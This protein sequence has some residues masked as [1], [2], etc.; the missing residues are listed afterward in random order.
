ML[1]YRFKNMADIYLRCNI[2]LHYFT[3]HSRSYISY[4]YLQTADIKQFVYKRLSF[5]MGQPYYYLVGHQD[6]S[7]AASLMRLPDIVCLFLQSLRSVTDAYYI[8]MSQQI[9]G[10][11]SA[12]RQMAI[13]LAPSSC[14]PPYR[15]K[16]TLL[17]SNGYLPV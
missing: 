11:I 8:G 14:S 13:E 15:L 12:S 5:R 7:T 3:H 2:R 9:N 1:C 6:C 4:I 10:S 17:Q 16:S